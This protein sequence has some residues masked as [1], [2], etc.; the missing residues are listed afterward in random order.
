MPITPKYTWTETNTEISLTLDIPADQLSANTVD[1]FA[2]DIFVKVNC[3]P[4]LFMLDLVLPIAPEKCRT[5]VEQRQLKLILTKEEE[6]MWLAL[7]HPGTKQE[8]RARRDA[9]IEKHEAAMEEVRAKRKEKK[10]EFEGT[11][12]KTQWALRDKRRDAVEELKKEETEEAVASVYK[13]KEG[14]DKEEEKEQTKKGKGKAKKAMKEALEEAKEVP[15]KRGQLYS[16][17]IWGADEVTK[18]AKPKAAK[19]KTKPQP[20]KKEIQAPRSQKTKVIEFDWSERQ[21]KTPAREDIDTERQMYLERAR[22]AKELAD[23][24]KGKLLPPPDDP[25]RQPLVLK[26]KGDG[27]YR[28]GDM[29]GAVSAYSEA[30]S[31]IQEFPT[32]DATGLLL[33]ACFSNRSACYLR[34]ASWERFLPQVDKSGAAPQDT[35]TIAHAHPRLRL[36]V[37]DCA[38]GLSIL[39]DTITPPPL[40]PRDLYQRRSKLHAR[41]ASALHLAGHAEAA[42]KDLRTGLYCT[43]KCKFRVNPDD[44]EAEQKKEAMAEE[45]HKRATAEIERSLVRAEDVLKRVKVTEEGLLKKEGDVAMQKGDYAGA[46]GAYSAALALHPV[47][48]AAFSNRAACYLARGQGQAA[49]CD[50][51]CALALLDDAEDP[52]GDDEDLNLDD[53]E[54]GPKKRTPLLQ[55]LRARALSRRGASL[56]WLGKFA[57]ARSDLALAVELNPSDRALQKDLEA[58]DNKLTGHKFIRKA[59]QAYR[60]GSYEQ[61][62]VVYTRAVEWHTNPDNLNGGTVDTLVLAALLSN[63]SACRLSLCNYADAAKDASRAVGMAK[64]HQMLVASAGPSSADGLVRLSVVRRGSAYA[65]LGELDKAT[66]DYEEVLSMYDAEVARLVQRKME[67][68]ANDGIEDQAMQRLG[69]ERASVEAD[70]TRIRTVNGA[71]KLIDEMD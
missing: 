32:L 2:T 14:A 11:L 58:V 24:G 23:Q 37:A 34:L 25:D 7:E 17:E 50:S 46:I 6:G 19:A 29:Q 1:V 54:D 31:L 66:S 8:R 64:Q 70:L 65:W 26:E 40:A 61:A 49:F 35:S 45:R 67:R 9:S 60:K 4:W 30:V 53:D 27:F 47:N 3:T 51:S 36:C 44:E 10:K 18:A 52:E 5:I 62:A 48:L 33:L 20:K 43:T 68:G 21:S 57:S 69:D 12:Q 55:L 41:R 13:W 22:K 71:G 42:A 63:R 39:N 59:A 28:S 56:V 38:R 16:K 15:E